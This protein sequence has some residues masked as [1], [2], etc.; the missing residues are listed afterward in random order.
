MNMPLAPHYIVKGYNT[1]IILGCTG[2][3]H[4]GTWAI[5]YTMLQTVLSAVEYAM[6]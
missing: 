3:S 5:D 4:R 6:L 2:K 1:I